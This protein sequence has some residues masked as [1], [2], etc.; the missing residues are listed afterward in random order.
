[1]R[2]VAHGSERG[3]AIMVVSRGGGAKAT[4]LASSDINGWGKVGT[5]M[6]IPLALEPPVAG[7][8]TTTDV[9]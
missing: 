9:N 4:T 7:V 1:V 3:W 6:V 2:P 5:R 8:A